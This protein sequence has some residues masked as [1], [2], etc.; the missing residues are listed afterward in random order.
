MALALRLEPFKFIRFLGLGF[1]FAAMIMIA[2][3]ETS[4]SAD[5]LAA[6]IA[7]LAPLFYV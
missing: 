5:G 7:L 2:M 4:L 1:G 6:S 3:P